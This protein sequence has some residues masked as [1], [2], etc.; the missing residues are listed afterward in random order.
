MLEW[1]DD[2]EHLKSI[3]SCYG[4]GF[5]YALDD[6]GEGFSTVELFTELKPHYMKLDMKDVQGVGTDEAKQ[7]MA[8][9]LLAPA[10]QIGAVPLAEG[11][12]DRQDFEWLRATG[13]ELFQGY[14]FGKPSPEPV[15]VKEPS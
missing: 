4:R 3:L 10:R 11:V 6:V 7:F 15:K 12:E 13:Y 5:Q 9:K 2:I 8:K 1:L 14:L